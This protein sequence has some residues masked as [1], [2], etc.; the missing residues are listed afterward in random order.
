MAS[1]FRL[2]MQT[3]RLAFSLALAKAGNSIAARIAMIAITTSNSIKVNALLPPEFTATADI[4][5]FAFIR[6]FFDSKRQ[7]GGNSRPR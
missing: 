1:C 4:P 5:L 6:I 2:F 3:V 7:A